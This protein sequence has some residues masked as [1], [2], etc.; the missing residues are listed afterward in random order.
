LG[1]TVT[2]KVGNAVVRNR[3]RRRLKAA[4]AQIMPALAKPGCDYVLIGRPDAA[5]IDLTQL[6]NEMAEGMR[7]L[8]RILAQKAKATP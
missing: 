2:K 5:G 1:F 7:K 6:Q 4:A 8:H 3:A